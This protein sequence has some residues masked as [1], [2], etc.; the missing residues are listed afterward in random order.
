MNFIVFDLEWNQCPDGK[1]KENKDLPFEIVEIGAVKLN[2]NREIIDE[3]SQL[4]SPVVYRELHKI[5]KGIIHLSMKDL[6]EGV[7]FRKAA[8]EF[9]EWCAKGGEYIFCSWGALDLYELQRNC[10]YFDVR[11]DFGMPLVFYDLQKLYSLCFDDGKSRLSLEAAVD[12][13]GLEKSIP[14]HAALFDAT[15][16]A[17]VFEKIDFEKVKQYTSVD[18]FVIPKNRKEE[19]TINYGTYSKYVSRGFIDRDAAMKDGMVLST[20]CYLCGKN[21]RKRVRWFSNNQRMFYCLCECDVH[22]YVKGKI[23]LKKTDD[24][25]TYVIKTMKIADEAGAK[26]IRQKQKDTRDKR[27]ERRHREK[28]KLRQWS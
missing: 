22:G 20:V 18:T 26:E 9:F 8:R 14:F 15:Y 19:Y 1:D 16:T 13:L 24:D 10:R 3:Y 6:D 21:I 4:V 17:M 12:E 5:T 28:E 27:R 23:R 25:R 2:D 7:R 11:H